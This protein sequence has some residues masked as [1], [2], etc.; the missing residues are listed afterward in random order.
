MD[1]LARLG[2]KDKW[3]LGGGKGAIYAP[4]FPKHLLAPGFWDECYLADLRIPRLFTALFVDADGRPIKFESYHKGWRPDRLT[5][6][7]YSGDVVIRE[8]RCVTEGN[9]W[10]TELE[11]VTAVRPVHVFLWAL[12]D[13]RPKGHGT[14]WQAATGVQVT[15]D[16]MKV[17]FETAWPLE[18]E[19]DRTGVEAER[20]SGGDRMLVPFPL[21]LEFG[22]S[23]ERQSW[24]VNLAQRH[25]DS[26]V[27]ETSVLPEK[28][29]GG[30]LPEDF[31]LFVGPEPIEGMAD[32][33]QHYVLEDRRPLTLA[34]GSGLTPEAAR[35]SL[36]DAR[37]D[38]VVARSTQ[39]WRAYFGGVPQFE[40][41]DPWLTNAYW[42]R[43]YGLRLNTVDLEGSRFAPFVTEGVG[44]FRNFVTYSAQA[45]LREAAWMHDPRLAV[46]ILDNL[47]RIQREDGSFPG[48]SYSARPSR[49]F[50]HADYAAGL[51][52]LLD[53]HGL[54][55]AD[56][57]RQAMERYAD[58]LLR[59]RSH[60]FDAA[61]YKYARAG[62]PPMLLLVFDQNETGQEYMSRYTVVNAD[63]DRWSS[64]RVCGVDASCYGLRL[65]KLLTSV[66]SGLFY[67]SPKDKELSARYGTAARQV[68]DGIAYVA[69]DES[70]H[71]FCDVFPDGSR[72]PA[73]P[74]T[75]LYPLGNGYETYLIWHNDGIA[76]DKIVDRWL[77][78]PGQFWLPKGF[79]A[80]AKSDATFSAEG[81]W[82][83]KR[84]NCP[85]GGRS[86][87]MA[88]SHVVEGAVDASKAF[89]TMLL[90]RPVPERAP[91]EKLRQNM[92]LLE[93]LERIASQSLV[94]A[95]RLMFHDGNPDRPNS[96]EHYDP[97]TGVP[98]L[99]RG[100]DDSMHS[101]IVDLILRHAVGVQP[102]KDTVAPLA[103]DV[104]WIECTD[105]PHPRGRMHVRLERGKDPLVEIE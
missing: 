35:K 59:E 75:G 80:T 5:I 64:F 24:T 32:L 43:W 52:R 31:K 17:R 93:R 88:N 50:Y 15:G 48:H 55:L 28:F 25:D 94:K 84:L 14:P 74:I 98:S 87:P 89:R 71:F 102:G 104:D 95:I 42:Y 90:P 7:H 79:P 91:E 61:N 72:S 53:L 65:L 78:D 73:R 37:E 44:F 77:V 49:D 62:W 86:W 105:I 39:A 41:S 96:Y 81:E 82:K 34:C 68:Y 16:S 60:V 46:G 19:P 20:L 21:F 22:A 103:L 45:H 29:R 30:R 58:Y 18:L 76:I 63:A 54:P 33:V 3:F 13:V 99:Y 9:A 70:E 67:G 100:Y 40:S 1:P 57:H 23:H 69:C 66:H 2:R 83:E 38:G 97:E 101:W 85:W 27:Y 26:P 10:A 6:M 51:M 47:A 12:M 56:R 11:L 8:I 92:A 4:P 36:E